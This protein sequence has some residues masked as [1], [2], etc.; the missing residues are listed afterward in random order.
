MDRSELYG[1]YSI[2]ENYLDEYFE[3]K[4]LDSNRIEIIEKS[5]FE[6]IKKD[7]N[8]ITLNNKN[9]QIAEIDSFLCKIKES[10][11]RTGLHICGNRQNDIN[12]INLF[13]CIAR[14]PN[15]NRIGVIQYI[16]KHLK[17]DL[18]PWTNIYDQKLSEKDKKI[19]LTFSNKNILNLSL[20]H[21]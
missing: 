6:L 3:A 9:N 2:L 8:E 16:A 13:L 15:A 11:I 20:I 17:L 14:V 1:K 18:D 10:Q 5:I 21:I 7:F 12:E 4:L 19:L